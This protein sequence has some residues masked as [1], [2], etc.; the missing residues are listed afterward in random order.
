MRRGLLNHWFLGYMFLTCIRASWKKPWSFHKEN[1]KYSCLEQ[2]SSLDMMGSVKIK[3]PTRSIERANMCACIY[4]YIYNEAFSLIVNWFWIQLVNNSLT[5][6]FHHRSSTTHQQ[7]LLNKNLE[8][9]LKIE[10]ATPN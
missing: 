2:K 1:L 3:Y 4:I 9:E 8:R 6:K 7:K 5:T 10:T